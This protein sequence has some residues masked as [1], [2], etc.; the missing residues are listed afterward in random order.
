M[1]RSSRIAG[2][3]LSVLL[4]S[5]DRSPAQTN[6]DAIG[7]RYVRPVFAGTRD[8]WRLRLLEGDC[9]RKEWAAIRSSS[10]RFAEKLGKIPDAFPE[11]S[12]ETFIP[13]SRFVFNILQARSVSKLPPPPLPLYSVD[14][15]STN[16]SYRYS[17]TMSESSI[18]SSR[19]FSFYYFCDRT[20][21]NNGNVRPGCTGT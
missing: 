6:V 13:L 11:E 14:L 8:L 5:P 18:F 3:L 15:G 20:L 19:S 2:F 12:S 21:V 9:S 10:D 17:L 16:F 1:H 4:F 7:A